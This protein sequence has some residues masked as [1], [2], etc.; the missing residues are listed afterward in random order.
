MSKFGKPVELPDP[1]ELARLY[2]DAIASNHIGKAE[3]VKSAM[4][5][6]AVAEAAAVEALMMKSFADSIG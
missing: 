6:L 5:N 4:Q 2:K 3:M 1:E